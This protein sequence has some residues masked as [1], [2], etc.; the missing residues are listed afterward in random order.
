MADQSRRGSGGSVPFSYNLSQGF[1]CVGLA[2]ALLSH[3]KAFNIGLVEG[4]TQNSRNILG[5]WS[6]SLGGQ[7]NPFVGLQMIASHS[8]EGGAIRA[9]VWNVWFF[10]TVHVLWMWELT[11]IREWLIGIYPVP[12]FL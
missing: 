8:A 2:P 4:N 6:G 11:M 12:F 10:C 9:D 3:G 7:A 1:G 5:G